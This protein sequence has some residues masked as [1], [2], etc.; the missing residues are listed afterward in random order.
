MTNLNSRSAL[1]PLWTKA[2]LRVLRAFESC[3]IAIF[4]PTSELNGLDFDPYSTGGAT[5][6]GFGDG[7]F[8]ETAFGGGIGGGGNVTGRG[9]LVYT[10]P[11][12][13][14]V[15]RQSLNADDVAGSITQLRSVR[16]TTLL[17]GP[18]LPVRKGLIVRVTS[19]PHDPDATMYEY[20]VTSGINSGLAWKRTIETES[21]MQVIAPPITEYNL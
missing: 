10:G 1:H 16:F 9:T 18:N 19:C 12:Q 4:D 17:E 21:D 14:Q 5:S 8:G 15:F 7:G 2:P 20:V 6:P 13:M 3:I 11:A